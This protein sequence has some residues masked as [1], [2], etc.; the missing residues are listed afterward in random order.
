VRQG[1][2]AYFVSGWK[3]MVGVVGM[4][5]F[6]SALISGMREAISSA[7]AKFCRPEKLVLRRYAYGQ[8][9]SMLA[10]VSI[11]SVSSSLDEAYDVL[12]GAWWMHRVTAWAA[13]GG[14]IA[15]ALISAGLTG[16]LFWGVVRFELA[17]HFVALRVII[18]AV[19]SILLFFGGA[20]LAAMTMALVNTLLFLSERSNLGLGLAKPS[21]NLLM[22]AHAYRR[23][24]QLGQFT[25]LRY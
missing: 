15:V 13:R 23:P 24:L 21:D 16:I 18:N 6:L 25:E 7:T 22:S 3:Y 2:N 17:V 20:M 5:V 9:E 8:P 12:V 19:E 1:I 14:M 11:L 10:H 4:V